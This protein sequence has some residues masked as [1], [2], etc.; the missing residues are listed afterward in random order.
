MS[1]IFHEPCT[2][3]LFFNN[4]TCCIMFQKGE[5]MII[6]KTYLNALP[7]STRHMRWWF[8]HS[9]WQHVQMWFQVFV[10]Y[11]LL[12]H[13]VNGKCLQFVSNVINF[14]QIENE[15]IQ[16]WVALVDPKHS[17]NRAM[18]NVFQIQKNQCSQQASWHVFCIKRC[19]H[20][21]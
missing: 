21:Q 1:I 6:K 3:M 13:H 12:L 18:I 5:F 2:L 4:F 15:S 20:A 16:I 9:M 19:F 10:D 8:Y 11:G 17:L 7:W 14:S